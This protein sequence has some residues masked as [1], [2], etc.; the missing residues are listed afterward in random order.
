[1]NDTFAPSRMALT[2]AGSDPSGGAGLQAD[3]GVFARLGVHPMAVPTAI[4]VQNSSGVHG[5]YPL[6][7]Q[8]VG[9]QLRIL[10][11]DM[12]PHA[13]KT[14]MLATGDIVLAV[15]K[16]LAEAPSPHLVIDPVQQA[17]AGPE[18]LD[19]T[20][21][22]NLVRHL[23]PRAT[24]ITP[25]RREAERLW[26]R[27]VPGPIEAARCAVELRE[28]GPAAVL[29]TGGHMD[30]KGHITDVLADEGGVT[31]WRH[32][33]RPGPSPHGTGCALSAAIT[34]YLAQGVPLRESVRRALTY[35]ISAIKTASTP[36]RGRP[37]LGDG[38]Q[39]LSEELTGE[40]P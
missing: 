22:D 9:E 2:I 30:D 19:S 1:M 26:G 27:P 8:R 23:L 29:V 37:L 3:V 10:L 38:S 17:S 11:P 25:N 13:V 15:A 7:P 33:R 36:G 16:A 20:G 12:P 40:H 28:L 18:L 21:Y 5:V 34:A 24:L 31:T 6:D 14:G 4:T 32:P 35:V 39:D